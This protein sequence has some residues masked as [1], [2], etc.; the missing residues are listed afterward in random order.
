MLAVLYPLKVPGTKFRKRG[1]KI[2][3][4][5]GQNF[6]PCKARKGEIKT[7]MELN[8]LDIAIQYA[9]WQEMQDRGFGALM[10][11]YLLIGKH[12]GEDVQTRLFSTWK[13]D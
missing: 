3:Y 7:T 10:G 6:V 5:W 11:V 12:C 9:I 2:S 1:D 8:E 4:L 13:K